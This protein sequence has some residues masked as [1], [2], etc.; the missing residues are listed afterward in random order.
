MT[1][2]SLLA[3][4]VLLGST[5]QNQVPALTILKVSPSE[6]FAGN[7]DVT[8][9]NSH[10]RLA[11]AWVITRLPDRR[12]GHTSDNTTVPELG[13]PP[14]E[15]RVTRISCPEGEPLPAIEVTAVLYDDGT[16]G[17]DEITLERNLLSAQRRRA[18]ALR[19]LATLLSAAQHSPA[20]GVPLSDRF[21]T[22]IDQAEGAE[23]GNGTRAL[24]KMALQRF[25]AQ[26]PPAHPQS[27]EQFDAM[28]RAV[29]WELTNSAAQLEMWSQK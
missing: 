11:L 20:K 9:L 10:S 14:G 17:G 24:A 23:I 26:H 19:E 7:C 18:R 1:L 25:T 21:A 13:A 29:V 4:S 6:K 3:I 28:K 8:V 15:T 27:V 16:R 2:A 12:S 22:L 5:E